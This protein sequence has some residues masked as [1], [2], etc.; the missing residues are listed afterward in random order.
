MEDLAQWHAEPIPNRGTRAR[1]SFFKLVRRLGFSA[2][3][4]RRSATR[5]YSCTKKTTTISENLHNLNHFTGGQHP[6][7]LV[8]RLD[9]D[10]TR[11]LKERDV[12]RAITNPERA[13]VAV[14]NDLHILNHWR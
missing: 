4:P 12:V 14:A 9:D 10:P 8:I 5:W 1:P 2:L 7:G 11:D 6:G 13:G 3:I